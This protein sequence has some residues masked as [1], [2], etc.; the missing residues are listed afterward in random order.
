MSRRH[1]HKIG[2][3]LAGGGPLGA[4]YEIGALV[5]LQDALRGLDFTACDVYVGVSSGGVIA[6]GLANGLSPRDVHAMF[7]ENESAYEAFDPEILL[8]PA[9]GEYIRRLTS[10]PGLAF[11]AME[12]WIADPFSKGFFASF[13][14]LGR[15]IPTGIFDNVGF[16]AFLA[17][18]LS[19]PGRTDDFRELPHKLFLVAT[20]L[21]SGKAVPFGAPGWDHVP[22]SRAVQ[23][24]AALPGLFPPVEID[25]RNYV[26]GALMKTLHASVALK[27]GAKLLLCVNPL[28]PFNADLTHDDDDGWADR[29]S[30]MDRGLPAVMSQTFR[31]IIHSRMKVGMDRY[32]TEYPDADVLLFEPNQ[33]DAEIFF[34]NI[35]SYASRKRLA[36]HAYERTLAD[37]RR[38]REQLGPIFAAHGVTLDEDLLDHG[39]RRPITA[40]SPPPRRVPRH[41]ATHHLTHTLDRLDAALKTRSTAS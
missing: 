2:V 19:A 38:R 20:D 34:A 22:I 35:F 41:P 31:A 26:D 30:L 33:G 21:D 6:S 29:I 16:S 7:I 11:Q 28:V 23:A 9:F 12:H 8:R 37:L 13:Q 10:I 1:Q 3:A 15:A 32:R 39:R 5:A 40:G 18:L 27:E 14:R 4:I 17:K 25:G 36:Q 24:S